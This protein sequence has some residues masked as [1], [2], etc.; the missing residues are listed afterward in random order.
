[1]WRSDTLASAVDLN[2]ILRTL[3]QKKIPFLLTGA[4][5]IGGWTGRPRATHDVDLL[6]KSGRNFARAVNAVK[7]LYPH[8]DVRPLFG[9]TAFFIPGEKES[10]IDIIYP[11]RPEMEETLTHPV[12]TENAALG[13]RYRIPALECALA[14]KYGAILN[15]MRDITKRTLDVA[16]FSFM[17]KH[18]MDE[19]REPID[20]RRLAALGEMVW[21]AGEGDEVLR[22][23]QRVKDNKPIGFDNTGKLHST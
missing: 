14:N 12:W 2:Q 15:P 22:L 3:T 9:V 18:S 16:D 17:V 6:V 4:Y 7:K 19:G 11:H 5:A 10:V 8:L 23:V 1:M 13:L 21:P 20:L